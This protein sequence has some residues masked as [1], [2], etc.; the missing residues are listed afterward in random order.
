MSDGSVVIEISLD[1]TKADKHLIR[2]KKIWQKQR[3]GGIR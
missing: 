1:D 2:L 3:G